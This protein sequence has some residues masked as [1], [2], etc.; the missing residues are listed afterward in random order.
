MKLEAYAEHASETMGTMKRPSAED[1]SEWT[2][3][4][5]FTNVTYIVL[6][7]T[8]ETRSK[9]GH[10]LPRA[11]SSLPRILCF[12]HSHDKQ[13]ERAHAKVSG[14]GLFSAPMEK[15]FLTFRAKHSKQRR[16]EA[17]ASLQKQVT[18]VFSKEYIPQGTRFGP[19][20]G[21]VYPK[22]NVPAH[23][24]R[25]YFWRI[26]G[27]DGHLHHFIDGFD[28]G[29]SNWMRFVNPA[30]SGSEQNLVACQNGTQIYFYSLRP[31]PPGEELLVWYSS[32]FAHRLSRRAEREILSQ[33]HTGGCLERDIPSSISPES[34]AD[35]ERHL[36]AVHTL[37]S[38]HTHLLGGNTHKHTHETLTD[39]ERDT[40]PDTPDEHVMDF[41]KKPTPLPQHQ[42]LL[43]LHLHGLYAPR[44]S[45]L[46]HPSPH[47]PYTLLHPHYTHSF[48]PQYSPPF[49]SFLPSSPYGFLA[50]DGLPYPSIP[51]ASVAPASYAHSLPGV[52]LRERVLNSPP[53][54][55]ELSPA[56]TECDEAV[57]HKRFSSTSN[58]KT[59][60]RL[61][62]GE[63]PYQCKLCG[64]KF[65]QY[66]HLKLHRR[67]HSAG[68][69][70][71]RCPSC[72]QGF[73][74]GF[75]LSLHERSGCNGRISE[76]LEHFD[77]SREAQDL[78]ADAREEQI[79]A[80]LSSW[81]RSMENTDGK[82]D[83]RFI[84][85]MSG[86]VRQERASVLQFNHRASVK[87]EEE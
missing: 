23:S 67:L 71:H 62:S 50:S 40:P 49:P 61:H 81:I 48:P 79:H 43:P 66:I 42:T 76:L 36:H 58:L 54:T 41:S 45:L 5:F 30:R 15:L 51:Q 55:P 84:K 59:H 31:I 69:R 82:E 11:N 85:E 16:V 74:H 35:L 44:E 46:T 28:V 27:A 80:T 4:D 7:Q 83:F 75:S 9:R 52:G 33:P 25:K 1:T 87:T 21:I 32:E 24:N 39:I 10:P 63:K 19:L 34:K 26:Y 86:D 22:E 17:G 73:L 70:L 77:A 20:Q 68:D 38:G 65:T 37:S 3:Q 56:S 13:R 29:R 72:Q 78:P 47:T 8:T 12:H 60:L 6:D 64:V 18:G 53:A 14:G 2:E 57:C